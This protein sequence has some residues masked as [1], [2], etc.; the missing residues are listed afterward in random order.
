MV[1]GQRLEKDI[2]FIRMRT[3]AMKRWVMREFMT[4]KDES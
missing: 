2:N 1:V 4:A 3:L